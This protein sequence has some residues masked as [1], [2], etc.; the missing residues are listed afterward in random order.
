[1]VFEMIVL[2]DI[3]HLKCSGLVIQCINILLPKDMTLLCDNVYQ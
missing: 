3:F 2:M 1:M